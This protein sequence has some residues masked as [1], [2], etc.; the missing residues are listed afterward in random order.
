MVQDLFRVDTDFLA[1]LTIINIARF[2]TYSINYIPEPLGD[3]LILSY[4]LP[5]LIANYNVLILAVRDVLYT[6]TVDD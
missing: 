1:T 3:K 2:H 6:Y 5:G 4:V